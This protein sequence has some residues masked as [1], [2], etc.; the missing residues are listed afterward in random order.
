MWLFVFLHFSTIQ[1][2]YNIG[3]HII[4]ADTIQSSVLGCRMSRPGQVCGMCLSLFFLK[5]ILRSYEI[6]VD[7]FS[8]IYA[9]KVM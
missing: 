2:A 5:M 1:A 3:G 6:S 4:S 7:I 9:F 8:K